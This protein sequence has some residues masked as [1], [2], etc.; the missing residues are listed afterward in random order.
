[1]VYSSR[2]LA[3]AETRTNPVKGARISRDKMREKLGPEQMLKLL[4]KRLF[5]QLSVLEWSVLA[6]NEVAQISGIS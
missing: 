2:N 1:M 3:A 4:L 5:K 6:T